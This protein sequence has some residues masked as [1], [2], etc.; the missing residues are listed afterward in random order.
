[1]G[2]DDHVILIVEDEPLL[3]AAIAL[4]FEAA[5]W[6]VLQSASVE[7]ALVLLGRH[8]PVVVFTDIQLSGRLS[9]WD[10]GKACCEEGVPVIYT[11]GQVAPQGKAQADGRYFAKPYE[12]DAVL[13]ACARWRS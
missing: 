11:S 1:M 13:A 3:R 10:L 8:K 6:Q 9:G 4:H 2:A 7:Q 12:P 5:G